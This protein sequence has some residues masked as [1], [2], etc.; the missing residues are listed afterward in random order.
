MQVQEDKRQGGYPLFF[1]LFIWLQ[2]NEPS[3]ANLLSTRLGAIIF[4]QH[5]DDIHANQDGKQNH[6]FHFHGYRSPLGQDQ[7]WSPDCVARTE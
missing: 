3:L 1:F 4:A 2:E 6:H 7:H 5:V